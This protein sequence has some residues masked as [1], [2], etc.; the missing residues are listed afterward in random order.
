MTSSLDPKISAVVSSLVNEQIPVT[1]ND[2]PADDP[3]SNLLLE[4]L[5]FT[6]M[7]MLPLLAQGSVL[8]ILLVGFDDTTVQRGQQVDTWTRDSEWQVILQGIAYQIAAA[9]E[10]IRLREAQREEAYVSS[11]L[12]QVARTVAGHSDLRDILE[13]VAR[14]TPL[15]IGVACCLVYIWDEELKSF[16]LSASYGLDEQVE[17]ELTGKRYAPEEFPFLDIVRSTQ[18]LTGIVSTNNIPHMSEEK[19]FPTEFARLAVLQKEFDS[20]LMGVPLTV[21]GQV[22]GVMLVGDAPLA[23]TRGWQRRMEIIEGIAQQAALAV[24]NDRLQQETTR[25]ERMERELQLARGIQHELLPGALPDIEGWEFAAAYVSAREVGGDLY[26]F[27]PLQDDRLGLVVADVA[28]KGLPAAL[29]MVS[30]RAL[31]RA[32]ALDGVAP[33]SVLGRVNDLLVPDAHAG[34]FVTAVYAVLSLESGLVTYANAG[35]NPPLFLHGHT[36]E[37]ECLRDLRGMAMGVDAEARVPEGTVQMEVGD[38][39][40]LYTDGITEAY[41]AQTDSF[42]GDERLGHVVGKARGKSAR[43]MLAAIRTEVADFVGDTPPSDDL[44]AIIARRVSRV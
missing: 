17:Q 42:F 29:F 16:S 11:A 35:H 36:G 25:A 6:Q 33:A 43:D 15:L 1:V 19:L 44:T 37:L 20:Q 26:D 21:K 23:V 32:A 13:A 9:V 41:S 2:S 27:I 4:T 5:G 14:I 38:Y 22:L 12:L 34:L 24:Q 18:G 8:G 28:D 7:L 40:I 30:T 39:L 31:T 10:S 3:A